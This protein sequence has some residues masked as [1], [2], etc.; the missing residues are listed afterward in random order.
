MFTES[1]YRDA[2]KNISKIHK[3]PT[4]NAVLNFT[5]LYDSFFIC[6]VI[7][8]SDIDDCIGVVC[9]NGG[10]CIDQVNAYFCDC[11][12]DFEGQNCERPNF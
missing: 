12:V 1:R 3:N 5:S 8:V 6:V 11:A 9:Q 2:Q 7:F 4:L 10:T